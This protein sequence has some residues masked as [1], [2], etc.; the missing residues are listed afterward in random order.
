MK[1]HHPPTI[2][3]EARRVQVLDY[4]QETDLKLRSLSNPSI[5]HWI[6]QAYQHLARACSGGFPADSKQEAVLLL[7][8]RVAC[9]TAKRLAQSARHP[10]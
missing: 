4:I 3:Y 2:S 1:S 8:A 6:T 7:K 9:G 5:E 10:R